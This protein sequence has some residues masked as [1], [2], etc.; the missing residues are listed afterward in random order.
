MRRALEDVRLLKDERENAVGS[1]QQEIGRINNELEKEK[2]RSEAYKSKALDA[3][4]RSIKAKEVLDSL[5][6][7]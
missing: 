7:K 1:L 2:R 3:H 5:C 4:L 6:N